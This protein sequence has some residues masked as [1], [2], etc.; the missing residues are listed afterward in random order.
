MG[1]AKVKCFW[2]KVLTLKRASSAVHFD[3]SI[4]LDFKYITCK[5]SAL[6]DFGELSDLVI[7]I[8]LA[9]SLS[10]TIAIDEA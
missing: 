8:R 9:T 2:P 5:K 1:R 3:A 6:Q 10:Q 7:F 4:V